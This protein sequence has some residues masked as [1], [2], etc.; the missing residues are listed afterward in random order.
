M[1]HIFHLFSFPTGETIYTA[2]R[3]QTSIPLTCSG[4]PGDYVKLYWRPTE[5]HDNMTLVFQYDRWR[6]L[7]SPI[8]QSKTLEL[9]GPPYNPETGSFSFVL[10]PWVKDGGLYICEVV[11]NDSA[12]GQW[13]MLSVVKGKFGEAQNE[14]PLPFNEY[15]IYLHF[16][17]LDL[18]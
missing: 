18:D 6:K 3:A 1:S 17:V 15:L 7:F 13:T 16:G 10:T 14:L 4:D 5:T 8:E 11:H 2:A 9:A 12:H